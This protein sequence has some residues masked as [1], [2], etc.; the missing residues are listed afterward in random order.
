M[1]AQAIL[2]LIF[3]PIDRFMTKPGPLVDP[4]RDCNSGVFGIA[5][6]DMNSWWMRTEKKA[7]M[8]LEGSYPK[9]TDA[10]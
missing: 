8:E 3:G 2:D 5:D 6:H 9:A 10:D 4:D 7:P 1:N